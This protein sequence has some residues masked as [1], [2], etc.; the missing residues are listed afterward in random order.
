MKKLILV[1]CLTTLVLTL[2]GNINLNLQI[3]QPKIKGDRFTKDLPLMMNPGDPL[4]PYMPIRVL[5]KPTETIDSIQLN[6]NEV[7]SIRN[8]IELPHALQQQPTSSNALPSTAKNLDIYTNKKDF[9]YNDYKLLSIQTMNGYRFAIINLYPYKYNPIEKTL[10]SFENVEI[11]IITSESARVQSSTLP[12]T[13]EL[14]EKK[15]NSN[16]YNKEAVKSYSKTTYSSPKNMDLST[17][18]QMIIL[19]DEDHEDLFSEFVE[20]KNNHNTPTAVYTLEEIAMYYPGYDFQTMLRGFITDAYNTWAST[21]TPLEYVLLGGDDEIIPIRGA[22]G[23]V[24]DH[25]DYSIPC[26]LYYGCL[27]GDW[28]ANGNSVYGEWNDDVDLYPELSVGRIPAESPTEFNNYFNKIYSYVDNVNFGDNIANMF[29]ENLNNNP[30]TWGGDYKDEIVDRM[31]SDYEIRTNYQRDGN[32]SSPEVMAAIN[33]GATIMNH[34]GHAN[35]NTV[36]GLNGSSISSMLTNTQYG[37]LFTQGCYPAAFDTA[38][39]GGTSGDSESVAEHFIIAEHGLHTFIGNT[40]YGWYWPGS[41]DGASQF[42]DRSFFDALFEEDIKELGK[43]HSYC[44]VDNADSALDNNAMLW[45]YY[46]LV[47]FGDPSISVKDF[48]TEIAYLDVTDVEYDDVI[49]DND[50]NINPTETIELNITLENLAGWAGVESVEISIE[51]LDDRFEILNAQT[52][53]GAINSGSSSTTETNRIKFLV[54]ENIAF[55]DFSYNL[56]VE[57][58]NSANESIFFNK[59]SQYFSITLMSNNFPWESSVGTRSSASYIDYNNDG[60]NEVLYVDTYGNIKLLDFN[61]EVI[62]EQNSAQQQN[63]FRDYALYQDD[64]QY[65]IATTSRTNHLILQEIGGDVLFTY[66]ANNIFIISPVIADINNDGQ[67]EVLAIDHDKYL[68]ALDFNGTELNNFPLQLDAFT[69]Y[70]LAIADLDNDGSNDIVFTTAD[71]KIHA[72]NGQANELDNYPVETGESI[73]S[74]IVIT[75][76]SFA[77][78]SQNSLKIY[79]YSGQLQ[80]SVETSGNPVDIIANNFNNNNLADYAFI[81]TNKKVYIVS[82]DG[83]I[84][85]GFPQQMS[86][87]SYS[88]PLSADVNNDLLPELICFDGN[89]AIY[90]YGNDGNMLPNYPFYSNLSSQTPATLGDINS[91]GFLNIALGYTQGLGLVNLKVDYNEETSKWTTYRNNYQRT[92]YYNISNVTPNAEESLVETPTML[93]GNYPNPFNPETRIA[94]ST[95]ENGPVSIDIFNVKGQ[96]VRSLVNENMEAGNHTVVWNGQNDNGKK[97]ASGLFFYRMKSGKYSSTK[98]MILMK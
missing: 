81:T 29:G 59:Y 56:V 51:G 98:K 84:F 87:S 40:R 22:W 32:F 20:W 68:H 35:E 75:N 44:L 74:S 63:I 23:N 52:T 36:C 11:E 31:P 97:V 13:F 27:D 8:N 60:T 53:L 6:F 37:F 76:N 9:P 14:V 54:P 4:V 83:S 72:I 16:F 88:A 38:T 3:E 57:G 66:Q 34:M 33:S 61:G 28:N 19:T 64:D 18:K 49:G 55:D 2:L 62:Y 42:F 67:M 70:D 1:L 91:D 78:A 47:M 85:N 82:E 65:L 80:H 69:I 96:K 30:V 86:T 71:S 25:V 73:N 7:K 26:D 24:G 95:K 58:F 92:G 93:G 21:D 17:P 48:N 94:F 15:L 46:E 5:L 89:N 12:T 43:A 79:N 77:F 39:S 90:V 41:T 10:K 45:C 50:G